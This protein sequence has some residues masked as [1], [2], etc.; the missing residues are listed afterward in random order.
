[1]KNIKS[2]TLGA[3]IAAALA[4]SMVS[5]SAAAGVTGN[6]GFMS[7]YY[8]RGINQSSGVASAGVDYEHEKG[9]YAGIWAADIGGHDGNGQGTPNSGIETDYYAGFGAEVEGLS[10]SIGFTS[11]QYTGDA[12]DTEYN[13]I[14]LNGGFGP[15][16]VEYS[17]GTYEGGGTEGG[18][19][20][21]YTFIAISGE[22]GPLTLTYGM[23]GDE[24]DGAYA[25]LG[26]SKTIGEVDYG[27][28]IINGDA[29]EKATNAASNGTALVFSLGTTFD[30]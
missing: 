19:D 7:D 1:M 5:T 18:P 3:A 21:D 2:L 15:V 28:S 10:Y 27:V 8:F 23:W 6:I 26:F 22:Y 24:V 12:F 14:N 17:A 13:E 29:D 25:E 16:G 4:G 9:I 11:Y 30:L 20:V